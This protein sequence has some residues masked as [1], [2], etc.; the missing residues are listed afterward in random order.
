MAA[1]TTVAC[2]TAQYKSL[3]KQPT[4][5]GVTRMQRTLDTNLIHVEPLHANNCTT[6]S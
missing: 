2:V 3:S 4:I 6:V 1:N 5:H